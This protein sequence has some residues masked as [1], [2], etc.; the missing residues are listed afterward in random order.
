ML[1]V[2]NEM[3]YSIRNFLAFFSGQYGFPDAQYLQRVKASLDTFH[4]PDV[5][6][7]DGSIGG[8]D[9]KTAG[10]AHVPRVGD[11]IKHYATPSLD[12]LKY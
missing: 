8:V 11:G 12:P 9:A 6:A 2:C 5:R 10:E 1:L 3:V 4:V 7:V